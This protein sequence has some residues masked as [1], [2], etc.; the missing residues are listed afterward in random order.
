[1]D[2]RGTSGRVGMLHKMVTLM[3]CGGREQMGV[4][5]KEP[6]IKF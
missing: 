3:F 6:I 1:M 2:V 5:N 4:E